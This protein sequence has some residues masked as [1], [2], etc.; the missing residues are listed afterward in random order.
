MW[1][2]TA[3]L[4]R[5]LFSYGDGLDWALNTHSEMQNCHT[6]RSTHVYNNTLHLVLTVC[7]MLWPEDH[8]FNGILIIEIFG[9]SVFC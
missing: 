4:E 8:I 5:R 1:K 6:A 7:Q 2:R 9:L 3:A